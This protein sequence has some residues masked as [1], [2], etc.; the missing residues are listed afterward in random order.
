[1]QNRSLPI[2]KSI[3]NNYEGKTIIIGT[4]GNVMTIIMNYFNSEYGY[5]FWKSTT[6]PD[7]YK[8]T[9]SKIK[10]LEVQRIWK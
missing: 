2:I 3:L 8:L 7:I 9:F 10:L 6:K 5:D 4:H 1:M